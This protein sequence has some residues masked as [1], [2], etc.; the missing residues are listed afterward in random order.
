MVS[1]DRDSCPFIDRRIVRNE[2]RPAECEHAPVMKRFDCAVERGLAGTQAR[3][4][5]IVPVARRQGAAS[6]ALFGVR[7]L[8]LVTSWFA[9]VTMVQGQR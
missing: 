7:V 3:V 6:G 1:D 9:A 2:S 8:L 4:R 5:M